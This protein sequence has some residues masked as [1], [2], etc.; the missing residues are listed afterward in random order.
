MIAKQ[1]TLKLRRKGTPQRLIIRRPQAALI[2][3][4]EKLKNRSLESEINASD[5]QFIHLLI[6]N[7]ESPGFFIIN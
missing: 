4:I 6:F 3:N 5:E 2:F 7:I 1:H